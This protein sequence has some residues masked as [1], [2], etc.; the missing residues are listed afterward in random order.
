M[1]RE[2]KTHNLFHDDVLDLMITSM[3]VLEVCLKFK[4]N[5][6]NNSYYRKRVKI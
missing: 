3:T 4:N 6:C 1:K 5:N 2:R